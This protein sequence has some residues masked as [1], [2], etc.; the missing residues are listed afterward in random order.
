MYCCSDD[1]SGMFASN[2]IFIGF[3]NE[4]FSIWFLFIIIVMVDLEDIN[5][6][7]RPN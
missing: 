7:L 4:K 1:W 6:S 5:R 2:Y 3:G